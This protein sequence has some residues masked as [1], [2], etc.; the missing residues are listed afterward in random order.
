[1]HL[2]SVLRGAHAY[3]TPSAVLAELTA[4]QACQR[5]GESPHSIAEIVAHMAFW[6]DWFLNRCDGIATPPPAHAELGWPTVASVRWDVIVQRFES[7]FARALALADDDTRLAQPI[8]PP[9]EFGHLK[10]YTAGDA[11]IHLSIHNAHHFGQV[12][13]LRQQ[14]QTWPPPAGSWTW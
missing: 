14:I 11:L 7:G 9:L 13:T 5:P 12:I 6:Q 2:H 4:E 3:L 8:T 1:M 10:H